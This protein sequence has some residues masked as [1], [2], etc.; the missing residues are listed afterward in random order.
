MISFWQ[1]STTPMKIRGAIFLL[2]VIFLYGPLI[3]IGFLAFQGPEGGLTFPMKGF[4]LYWFKQVILPDYLFDFRLPWLRSFILGIIV[5]IITI[6]IS[7]MAGL[8]YRRGFK[9]SNLV[10]YGVIG[11]LIAPPFLISLGIGLGF[12]N[13]EL[14]SSWYSGGLGAHLTWSLPFGV[15]IMLAIFARFDPSI[16]EA[17]TDLGATSWQR[18]R[19]VIFPIVLPGLIAIGLF[20]FTLSYDEFARTSLVAGDA[21]TLPV[22]MVSATANAARPDLYAVGTLTTIFSLLIIVLA[23]GV[24]YILERKRGIFSAATGSSTDENENYTKSMH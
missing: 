18:L 10:F 11:S 13:L 5:M 22:D 15:L 24:V 20:G 3:T 14:L 19:F 7:F 17:A 23:F 16:E 8:A 6:I 21:N 1:N 4:S 2:F 9:G 12:A